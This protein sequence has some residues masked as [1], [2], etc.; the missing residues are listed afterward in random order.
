MKKLIS[1]VIVLGIIG[2]LGFG[3]YK[4]FF[5]CDVKYSSFGK[6]FVLKEMDYAKVSDKVTV[7]LLDIEDD[8]CLEEPCEREGQFVVKFLIKDDRHMT[9]EKLGTL[10]ESKKDLTEHKLNYS[11]ELI[12][13]DGKT[14]TFNVEE[15]SAKKK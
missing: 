9:I 8:R 5:A 14:A 1:L 6:Y 13:T 2:F 7:K 10:S 12:E 3:I 4:F 15:I 11:I